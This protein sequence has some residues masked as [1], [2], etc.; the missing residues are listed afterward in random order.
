M[1]VHVTETQPNHVFSNFTL[2]DLL[3]INPIFSNAPFL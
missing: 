1:L 3:T 2:T